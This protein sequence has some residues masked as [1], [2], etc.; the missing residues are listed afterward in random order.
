MT[1][2]RARTM[3]E[4]MKAYTL[5]TITHP[6]EA[7]HDIYLKGILVCRDHAEALTAEL[8][9]LGLMLAMAYGGYNAL[10]YKEQERPPMATS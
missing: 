2:R 4:G 1:Y 6:S 9:H 5:E 8:E 3:L 7:D 10:H